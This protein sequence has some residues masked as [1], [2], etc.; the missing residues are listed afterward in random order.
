MKLCEYGCGLEAIHQLKSG[1]CVV[2]KVKI[3]VLLCE[4]NE[5]N[6]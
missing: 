1:K 2:V 3:L 6:Q 5:V 4:K